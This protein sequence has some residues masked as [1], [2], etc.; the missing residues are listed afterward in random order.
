[1]L[2]CYSGVSNSYFYNCYSVEFATLKS[3]HIGKCGGTCLLFTYL[4]D[5]QNQ[6]P[7][8]CDVSC[9]YPGVEYNDTVPRFMID[10]QCNKFE[11][12]AIEAQNKREAP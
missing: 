7:K 1:M 2:A 11:T 6:I 3:N 5:L 10:L 12:R 8:K 9:Y 4:Q